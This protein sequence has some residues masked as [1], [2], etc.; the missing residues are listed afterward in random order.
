MPVNT[1]WVVE[2]MVWQRKNLFGRNVYVYNDHRIYVE[3]E[4]EGS[5]WVVDMFLKEQHIC[6]SARGAFGRKWAFRRLN[7][8]KAWVFRTAEAMYGVAET[9]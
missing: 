2:D 5:G 1:A 7:Q 8:A 4:R 3:V 9:I 6:L